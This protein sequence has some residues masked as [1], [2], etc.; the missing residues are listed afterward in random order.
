MQESKERLIS[1]ALELFEKHNVKQSAMYN[2]I[3]TAIL[4]SV[5]NL[6]KEK[7]LYN[8]CYGVY[9][10]SDAFKSYLQISDDD[11]TYNAVEHRLAHARMIQDFGEHMLHKL[12]L[13]NV[14]YTYHYKNLKEVFETLAEIR[15]QEKI[16]KLGSVEKTTFVHEHQAKIK[17]LVSKL[18]DY[19]KKDTAKDCL[20]VQHNDVKQKQPRAPLDFEHLVLQHHASNDRLRVRM[21]RPIHIVK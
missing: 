10:Y 2:W 15:M 9:L 7:V 8:A 11:Y 20:I 17:E 6:P 21:L 12:Q 4:A 5:A 14:M 3:K 1:V 13:R 19:I 18:P 16:S